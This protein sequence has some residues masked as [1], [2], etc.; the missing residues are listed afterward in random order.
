MLLG[1]ER[2]GRVITDKER[3]TTAYHEA[4]HALVAASLANSDPIHKV[5][6]V[7]RGFAGGYTRKLPIEESRLRTRSQFLTDLAVLLG[8]YAAEQEIFGEM[9]T[10]ASD[11]LKKAS[12][13]ARKLVTQFGMSEKL[14]PMTFGKTQE[15]IFLG[16]EIATEKNYS[17]SV[18]TEIDREVK[19]FIGRAYNLAKK[20][21]AN[22]RKVLDAI[23][24][25]LLEKEVLEQEEFYAI[26][27]A[28]KLKPLTV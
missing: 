21:I 17:E 5:S 8:G 10:G 12:E 1:P 20:I 14:G 19:N 16:R 27:G 24:S 9:S 18:A 4:G 15:L 7:S 23:A 3:K 6:I 22:R 13:L 11:D 26:I 28:F 2:K 25:S